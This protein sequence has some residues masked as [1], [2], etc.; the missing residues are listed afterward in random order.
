MEFT[1]IDDQTVQITNSQISQV[2][3]TD[4][5]AQRDTAIIQ[6]ANYISAANTI[7]TKID[8][9]NS[10]ISGAEDVGVI[11]STDDET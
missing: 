6:K 5:I 8:E 10:I 1:K 2:V 4:I 7:Q 3:I 11:P 9:F